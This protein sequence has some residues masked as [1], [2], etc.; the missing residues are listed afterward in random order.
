MSEGP[1]PPYLNFV[2]QDELVARQYQDRE[3]GAN[4]GRGERELEERRDQRG[5]RREDQATEK[6]GSERRRGESGDEQRRKAGCEISRQT[7][8]GDDVLD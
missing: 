8:L 5:E 1:P 7:Y 3:G 4:S 2:M 6:R